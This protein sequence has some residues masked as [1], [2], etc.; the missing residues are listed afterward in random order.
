MIGSGYYPGMGR[1]NIAR[2]V[3]ASF[4]IALASCAS[5][6]DEPRPQGMFKGFDFGNPADMDQIRDERATEIHR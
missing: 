3:L 2:I 4:V 6:P 1:T 5:K